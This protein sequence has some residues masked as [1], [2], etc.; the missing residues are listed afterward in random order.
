MYGRVSV[1]TAGVTGGRQVAHDDG[2]PLR[3]RTMKSA[4]TVTVKARI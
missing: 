3:D 1:S 2:A 4:M